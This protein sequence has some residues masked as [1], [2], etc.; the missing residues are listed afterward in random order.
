VLRDLAYEVLG[1]FF[2]RAP[3]GLLR[4]A[5]PGCGLKGSN[6]SIIP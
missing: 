4:H 3:R 2:V 6:F 5:S 1:D